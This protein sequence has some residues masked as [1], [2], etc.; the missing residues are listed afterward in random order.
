MFATS[1]PV[2]MNIA[3]SPLAEW[4]PLLFGDRHDR[5]ELATHARGIELVGGDMHLLFHERGGQGDLG[6]DLLASRV[7]HVHDGGLL[8]G[9][10]LPL[11]QEMHRARVVLLDPGAGGEGGLAR[12]ILTGGVTG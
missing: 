2:A 5:A 4:L 9:R 10:E 6:D 1:W 7:Q 11:E 3:V 8:V 12:E